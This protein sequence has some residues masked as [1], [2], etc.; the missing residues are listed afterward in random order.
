MLTSYW[1]CLNHFGIISIISSIVRIQNLIWFGDSAILCQYLAHKL[2]FQFNFSSVGVQ[3]P[4][5]ICSIPECFIALCSRAWLVPSVSAPMSSTAKWVFTQLS[6]ILLSFT[7]SEHLSSQ[8]VCLRWCVTTL[9]AF[10]LTFLLCV[11]TNV[12]SN[13]SPERIYI[14]THYILSEYS[15]LCIFSLQMTQG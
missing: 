4:S 11:F 3:V 1:P 12:I 14:H 15:P 13:C 9:A 2:T 8:I 10:V 7:L 6:T 5:Q